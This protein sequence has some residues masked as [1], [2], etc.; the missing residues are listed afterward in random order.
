MKD[1]IQIN[2]NLIKVRLK[3]EYIDCE[4]LNYGASIFSLTVNKVDVVVGPKDINDFI[5]ADHHYGKTIGRFS[6]RL[7]LE[8]KINGEFAQLKPYKDNYSTIHGGKE[9]YARKYFDYEHSDDNQVIFTLL[10]K[11]EDTGLPGDVKLKVIYQLVG[12][13]LKVTYHA[14]STK[15]TL[16]N[17][18]NHSYFNLDGS[19]D[20]LNHTLKVN[21]NKYVVFDDLYN[22]L[23]VKDVSNTIYD[24]RKP[25]RL[26]EPIKLLKQT[27]FKGFDTI[28]LN[29]ENKKV[30]LYSPLSK[31]SLTVKSSYPALVVFT[32]NFASPDNVDYFKT[33][34]YH[35]VA[36]ECLYEPGGILYP[37]LNDAV[38]DKEE[39][40]NHFIS[41]TFDIK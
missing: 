40:Y 20:I 17:I 5:K 25:T 31:I 27:N 34:P 13:T 7:P 30:E 23:G 10:D 11:E 15:K 36:L 24:L 41:Y 18:T 26:K 12:K 32:H 19:N 1:I 35:G 3:N 33:R 38:I 28:F 16:I 4:L 39:V 37:F 21:A 2:K 22:I 8:V 6:G 14:V 29:D 9:G